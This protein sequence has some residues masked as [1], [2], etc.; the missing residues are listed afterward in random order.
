ME[1][2]PVI[3]ADTHV[4]ETDETWEYIDNLEYRPIGANYPP[5][6][7]RRRH[8]LIDG[9][10]RRRID[11]VD[12]PTGTTPETRELRDVPARLRHMDELGV[13][14][15]VMYPTLFIRSVAVRP[16]V[17]LAITRSYN[18]WI[19]EKSRE[20]SGRLRWIFL[21][22]PM[23]IEESLADMRWAKD[24]GA[25]G[26]MKM[27]DN[28]ARHAPYDPYFF[29]LYEEAERLG[30]PI[31]MHTGTGE[32]LH[33]DDRILPPPFPAMGGG[34]PMHGIYSIMAN[35]VP[36]Q[37]PKL[38]FGAVEAGAS[39]IPLVAHG[40]TRGVAHS[41][42]YHTELPEELSFEANRIYVTCEVDENLAMLLDYI[43]ED[44]LLIGSDYSH[45][46]VSNELEFVAGL[47]ELAAREVIPETAPRKFMYENPKRFYGL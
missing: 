36:A 41:H 1:R 8:W 17:E 4:D 44:N 35:R 23:N 7:G 43:S 22:S 9:Y 40:L 18:R 15:H 45:H 5:G 12:Y 37:F 14:V 19:A 38:R 16:E 31:C 27:G 34:T 10:K 24:H 11:F 42:L 21:P 46:D 28:E 13:D 6:A 20:A 39:W 33:A 2:I 29:P 3:D 25:C 26:V 30:M 32:I 47:H